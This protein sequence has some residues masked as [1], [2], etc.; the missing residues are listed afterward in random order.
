M[1]VTFEEWPKRVFPFPP[2][3]LKSTVLNIIG[4]W[5]TSPK[6]RRGLLYSEWTNNRNLKCKRVTRGH[7]HIL[8][9]KFSM[10]FVTI[11]TFG[12]CLIVDHKSQ[13]KGKWKWVEVAQECSSYHFM[14]EAYVQQCSLQADDDGWMEVTG[15][16]ASTMVAFFFFKPLRECHQ[17]L[18]NGVTKFAS[19]LA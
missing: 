8:M 12:T 18:A 5:R 11:N 9:I 14:G 2:R 10:R 3:F 16:N 19:N 4:D 13:V 6:F 17:Q 15:C 1:D 7:M